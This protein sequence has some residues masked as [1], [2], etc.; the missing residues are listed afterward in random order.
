M[1]STDFKDQIGRKIRLKGI[2]KRIVSLVPS[3]TEL[4]ADLGLD[5]E[6]TGIT[7]F[8]IH[9]EGWLK[10]KIIVGGTKDYKTTRIR[11][12]APDLIIANKEENTAATLEELMEEFPVWVSDISTLE[13]ALEMILTVG[14][15]TGKTE[16][17]AELTSDIRSGFQSL[18]RE[19]APGA[20]AKRAAYYIWKDPWLAAGSDTFIQDMLRRCGLLPVPSLSRYPELPPE[21][22]AE[23]R[24]DFVLLSSE[25]Y[26]FRYK[27]RMIF[28]GIV[29]AERILLTDGEYFSWYGSRLVHAPAYFRTLMTKLE[30]L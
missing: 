3:Q 30:D 18:E 17:A 6:V 24:P 25:P 9:P 26:P 16:K 5:E 13:E 7:R 23:L 19:V 10:R 21:E 15:M 4:L 12:L 8:C 2:P 20:G 11:E 28:E 29:P 1:S 14:E 22:L 27:H